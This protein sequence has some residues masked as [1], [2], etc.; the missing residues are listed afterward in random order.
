MPIA[1]TGSVATEVPAGTQTEFRITNATFNPDGQY[2]PD[3]ELDLEL[4]DEEYLGTS[5]RYWARVQQPRLD[6]VKKFQ[7]DGIDDETIASILKKQGFKFK[8]IDEPDT[9]TVGRSGNLYKMLTAVECS[10]HGA[11]AALKRCN[12]FYELAECLLDGTFIGTTRRSSDG[13]YTQ[14]DGTEDIFPVAA[15]A[16]AAAANQAEV[17]ELDF[18]DGMSPPAPF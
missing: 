15:P 8:K 3:I 9:F 2:G 10:P 6:K 4:T 5:L 7:K 12:S 18:D 17:D 14:L 11:E 13:K 1:T 16:A